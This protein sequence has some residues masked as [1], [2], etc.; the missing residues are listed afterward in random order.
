MRKKSSIPDLQGNILIHFYEC[1]DSSARLKRYNF[2]VYMSMI[3]DV[4]VP[5]NKPPAYRRQQAGGGAFCAAKKAADGSRM[6][7]RR[8]GDPPF[9][10]Y[11]LVATPDSQT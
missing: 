3:A 11:F 4:T 9:I 8:I 1:P 7:R 10:Y 2:P 5:N 6:R